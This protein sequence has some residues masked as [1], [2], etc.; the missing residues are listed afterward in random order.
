MLKVV[1]GLEKGVSGEEFNKDAT[2][3]PNVAGEAPTKV[4]DNLWST[5]MP[6]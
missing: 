6:C 2:Y 5:I 3:T 1:V 4:E